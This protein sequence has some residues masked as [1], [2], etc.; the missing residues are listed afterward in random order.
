MLPSIQESV[1][2]SSTVSDTR[3]ITSDGKLKNLDSSTKFLVVDNAK[4]YLA[5]TGTGQVTGLLDAPQ[6]PPYVTT[7]EDPVLTLTFP[8]TFPSAFTPDEELGEGTTLTVEVTAENSLG[9][10][11]PVSDT[12][13]PS[14]D[15]IQFVE[16]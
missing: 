15:A 11:G 3:N 5:F 7:D 12:V 8:S 4:K 10:D 9:T 6:S 14:F 2:S 1:L 16:P 13:Q